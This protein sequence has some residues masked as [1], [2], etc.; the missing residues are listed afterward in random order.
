[1]W[2]TYWIYSHRLRALLPLRVLLRRPGHLS[3]RLSNDFAR[4]Y[5]FNDLAIL[6][7]HP[8]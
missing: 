6:L 4:R 5:L 7:E 3:L 1:M 8:F 2:M